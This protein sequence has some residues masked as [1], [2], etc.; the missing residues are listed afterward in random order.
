LFSGGFGKLG[1][2]EELKQVA[3]F[4]NVVTLARFRLI[5]QVG[6]QFARRI[7]A[8]IATES[9]A[10]KALESADGYRLINGPPTAGRFARRTTNTA[11]KRR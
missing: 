6:K 9:F 4:F 3:Q 5:L 11:A 1:V 10:D 2:R 7:P 8:G